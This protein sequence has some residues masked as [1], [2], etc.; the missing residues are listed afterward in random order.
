MA[1]AH[2]AA[3]AGLWPVRVMIGVAV[4]SFLPVGHGLWR[5]RS[6]GELTGR[7]RRRTGRRRGWRWRRVPLAVSGV[8]ERVADGGIFRRAGGGH[9]LR[10]WFCWRP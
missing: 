4:A 3:L 9:Y 1:L 8:V 10:W 2:A 6:A 7:W 5:L